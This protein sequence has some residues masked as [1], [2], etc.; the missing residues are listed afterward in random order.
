[1]LRT[2]R[3]LI[4][5]DDA[6]THVEGIKI[7][8][9]AKIVGT[10]LTVRSANTE[11]G[12]L[13]LPCLLANAQHISGGNVIAKLL[14]AACGHTL[15]PQAP[16]SPDKRYRAAQIDAWL[17]YSTAEL[18]HRQGGNKDRATM[19][20]SLMP[21]E[22]ALRAQ[23]YLVQDTL[24]LAD[25]VIAVD[26]KHM[27]SGVLADKALAN[28]TRWY[29]TILSHPHI[30][31][32]T[33]PITAALAAP[34]SSSTPAPHAATNGISHGQ[35]ARGSEVSTS[36][37]DATSPSQSAPQSAQHADGQQQRQAN[38]KGGIPDGQQQGQA[39]PKGKDAKGGKL[40][41]NDVAKG[42]KKGGDKKD[43]PSQAPKRDVKKKKETKL[44][45]AHSKQ[46]SFGDW[47]S[48]VVVESEMISYYDV[49]GCYILRPWAYKVWEFIQRWFDDHIKQ[50]GVENAYFPLF[51][52]EEALKAEKDHVEGFAAEVAWVTKSG[53]VIW[54]VP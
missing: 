40:A 50:A 16:Y 21:L 19:M 53:T 1:M 43:K 17:D 27:A 10:S 35:A 25:I 37:S 31:E 52:T 3:V 36:Q 18:Q 14:V 12:K 11:D 7:Q 45:L 39:K 29:R 8:A 5:G 2:P 34:S 26:I 33:G 13:A 44:G 51:V 32:Y 41:K 23:T 15:Y 54:S 46:T 22:Q 38:A 30:A 9:I 48:E 4:I 20:N 28:V 42:Q 6:F 49:S 47:Y 24:S